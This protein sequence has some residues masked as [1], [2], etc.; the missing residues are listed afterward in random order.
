MPVKVNLRVERVMPEVRALRGL[1]ARAE[2]YWMSS[3][4]G[5]ATYN[6]EHYGNQPRP[7]QR[8]LEE[9]QRQGMTLR[10]F[11]RRL[12]PKLISG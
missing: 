5:L 8:M 12:G 10:E 2:R 4:L 9:A 7:F 11:E 1:L 6:S 3:A